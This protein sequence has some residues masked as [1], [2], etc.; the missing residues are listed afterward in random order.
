MELVYLWVEE[1]KNIKNQGFRFSPRFECEFDG[2]N[3][4]ITEN[5][6]YVSI[7]PENINVTAIVGE[8]GS[9]KTSLIDFINTSINV[10]NKKKFLF[11]FSDENQKYYTSN[12]S[13]LKINL[14]LLNQFNF[15]RCNSTIPKNIIINTKSYDMNNTLKFFI[16]I[17]KKKKEK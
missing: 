7:F 11:L 5:K 4:T 10:K 8:N 9:G 16:S 12:L 1:Y 17:F 2:D 3:L 6:D 14:T 15:N 13:L